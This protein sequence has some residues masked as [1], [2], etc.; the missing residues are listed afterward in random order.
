[1]ETV[2]GEDGVELAEGLDILDLDGDEDVLVGRSDVISASVA[3]VARRP[4]RPVP[5]SAERGR[6]AGFDN[7]AQFFARAA[8]GDGDAGGAR[9]GAR[10]GG[11][12]WCRGV[13]RRARV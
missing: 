5:A 6:A 1:I 8:L 7:P 4:L 11:G 9:V 13:P 12:G 2:D 10:G 3:A